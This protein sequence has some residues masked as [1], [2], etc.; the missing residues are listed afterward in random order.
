MNRLTRI[1]MDDAMLEYIQ[2]ANSTLVN[3]W[4]YMR[5]RNEEEAEEVQKLID[6]L[7]NVE[8]KVETAIRRRQ[9]RRTASFDKALDTLLETVTALKNLMTSM[10][11]QLVDLPKDTP[12]H[13]DL[14]LQMIK[15]T[16]NVYEAL[17]DVEKVA[18]DFAIA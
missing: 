3:L 10:E 13:R 4:E 16:D 12:E 14:R 8:R 17:D 9:L 1:A 2:N 15:L 7:E 5:R 6:K 11:L 18:K